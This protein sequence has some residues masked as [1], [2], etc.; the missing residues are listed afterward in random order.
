M[1]GRFCGDAISLRSPRFKPYGPGGQPPQQAP[2]YGMYGATPDLLRLGLLDPRLR[3]F[4]EP[5][6]DAN[7]PDPLV[8]VIQDWLGREKPISVLDFSGVP[9]LASDLAIGVVLNLLFEIS[10]RS[11]PNGPGIG[12]PRPVLI[13]LEEAHRYIAENATALTR[14]SANRIAREGRKYGIGLLM[15]TQRPT[16]LPKTALAQCGTLIALRLSN[17]EDQ[18]AIR[19]ALPDTVSGLAA[20]LPSL[21]TGEAIISGEALNIARKR[22]YWN[23]RIPNH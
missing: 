7:G 16:E 6:G 23:N 15:V 12:R 20:V 5:L 14:D 13:V 9:T 21:R 4:R 18:G 17:A 2:T 1:F 19:A 10:I 8:E 11:E 3:F 22:L